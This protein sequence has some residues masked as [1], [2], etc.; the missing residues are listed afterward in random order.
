MGRQKSHLCVLAR[1]LKAMELLSKPDAKVN[2]N[3]YAV[4]F[5]CLEY[6]C[7]K[8]CSIYVRRPVF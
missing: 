8:L 5:S 1:M 4:G 7:K 6:V 2:Q 3:A